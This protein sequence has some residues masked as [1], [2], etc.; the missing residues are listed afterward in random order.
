MNRLLSLRVRVVAPLILFLL[1]SGNA[2]AQNKCSA[3]SLHGSYG[4]TVT[5]TNVAANVQFAV[6]GKFAA[7]GNGHFT[8]AGIQSVA[9]KI[10]KVPFNGSYTI[11]ADCLGG[12]E[13]VFG[14]GA[15]SNLAFILVDDGAEVLIMA[16]D[17]GTVETG[18]AKKIFR[19]SENND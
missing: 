15:R 4:F 6:T 19:H 10:E 18:V 11:G 8:G 2:G 5:G 3:K 16:G 14:S 13:F 12:A 1:T 7:D 17:Q 9:G